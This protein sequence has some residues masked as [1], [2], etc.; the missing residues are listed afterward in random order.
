MTSLGKIE[1]DIE[2]Y[3]NHSE[4]VYLDLLLMFKTSPTK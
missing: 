1:M 2:N 3:Y 4:A